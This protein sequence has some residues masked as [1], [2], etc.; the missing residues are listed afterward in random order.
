MT[1]RTCVIL[2]TNQWERMPMLRHELAAALLFAVRDPN[3][4][5]IGLPSVVKQEVFVH[6]SE[7]HQ[8]AQ[9]NLDKALGE[10]RQI[11]GQSQEPE[12]RGS[13]AV[14][15]AFESRISDLHPRLQVIE[16]TDA[17][18]VEAG[19]MVMSYSP[20]STRT[21]QQYKDSVLWRITLRTAKEN[22]VILVTNDSGFYADKD[23]EDLAPALASEIAELKCEVRLFR[24]VES[25]IDFWEKD[26]PPLSGDTLDEIKANVNDAVA[27]EIST[28]A[29]MHGGLVAQ[30]CASSNIKLYLTEDHRLLAVSGSFE[31]YLV[32]REFP[33]AADPSAAAYVTAIAAVDLDGFDVSDIQLEDLRIDVITSHNDYTLA[34]LKFVMDADSAG[35]QRRKYEIRRN[36]TIQE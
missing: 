3:S 17:D 28:Y 30:S 18:L 19:R 32:D 5:F 35:P 36:L 16:C 11:F 8:K 14:S 25:F 20:P 12:R 34:D 26:N 21:S 33:D 22:S 29:G 9:Q 15:Q 24:N 6:L 1:S 10:I 7:K 31:Y 27:R 2:D 23:N 4:I 13:A